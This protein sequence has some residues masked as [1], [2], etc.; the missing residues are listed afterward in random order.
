[1]GKR[2][3]IRFLV[4]Y[5]PSYPSTKKSRYQ[6]EVCVPYQKWAKQEVNIDNIMDGTT[7]LFF[8]GVVQAN[9]HYESRTH[10][11]ALVFFQRND[12]AVGSKKDTCSR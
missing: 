4:I 2:L 3:H 8:S 11:E 9:E 12:M 10:K 6:C 5:F 7:V 1:M